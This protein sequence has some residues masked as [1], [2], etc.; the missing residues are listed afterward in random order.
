MEAPT[1][2]DHGGQG[3]PKRNWT[4]IVCVLIL[5]IVLVNGSVAWWHTLILTPQLIGQNSAEKENQFEL[6]RPDIA[7]LEVNDFLEI[8]KTGTVSLTG[9]RT[10]ML[11]LLNDPAVHGNYALYVEDLTTGAWMGLNEREKF[12]P[13]SLAKLP[14]V[15]AIY[16]RIQ[17]GM[18]SPSDK[19]KLEATDIDSRFGTL[20]FVEPGAEYTIKDLI[21]YTLVQSDN[22]AARTLLNQLS[23][24]DVMEARLAMGLDWPKEKDD[25]TKAS[26]KEYANMFRSLY[27]STYL[28]RVFSN[29]IL[30][31]LA[32]TPF[33]E[34]LVSGI[35]SSIRLAHKYGVTPDEESTH[36]CG[37]VYL[38]DHH[39]IICAMSKGATVEE[40]NRVIGSA[41][42]VTYEF[43]TK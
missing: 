21:Y 17:D 38:K 2:P 24:D 41:S 18:I 14:I 33:E 39:Y 16:K 7:A 3:K 20:G 4:L 6:I 9:L 1:H 25:V 29:E 28:R 43:M 22:T 15:V 12:F 34:Q 36:D 11:A 5:F 8:Q 35:P 31:L 19:I 40:A 13:A 42:K 32:D 23:L 26:V 37:I 30:S 27:L 10:E